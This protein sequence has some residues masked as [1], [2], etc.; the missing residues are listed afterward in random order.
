MDRADDA[1]ETW[2][3]VH[4]LEL[5]QRKP[6]GP[7]ACG[8]CYNCGEPLDGDQR[9]CDADCEQDWEK[10]EWAKKQRIQD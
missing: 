8:H 9:W 6:A 2:A 1:D 7:P 3:S 4:A 10:A 5:A